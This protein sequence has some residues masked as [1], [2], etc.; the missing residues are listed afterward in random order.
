MHWHGTQEG[1]AGRKPIDQRIARSK[2]RTERSRQAVTFRTSP[3][4][5][6]LGF[7]IDVRV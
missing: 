7:L 3:R 5:L 1:F 4:V 2:K 6:R